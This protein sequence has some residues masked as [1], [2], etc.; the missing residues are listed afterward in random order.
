MSVGASRRDTGVPNRGASLLTDQDIA[1]LVRST[2]LAANAAREESELFDAVL[3]A[4]CSYLDWEAAAIWTS[5][6]HGGWYPGWVHVA[7]GTATHPLRTALTEASVPAGGDGSVLSAIVSSNATGSAWRLGDDP[8]WSV[9]A[10]ATRAGCRT[11]LCLGIEADGERSHLLQLLTSEARRPARPVVSGLETISTQLGHVVQRARARR[12]LELQEDELRAAIDRSVDAFLAS[13]TAGRIREWNRAAADLFGW[14][15]EEVLG[16]R[17]S[18]FLIPP[19]LRQAHE[20]D[21]RRYVDTGRSNLIDRATETPALHRDGHEI[22]VEL[23]LWATGRGPEGPMRLNAFVRDLT[24][25]YAA[26]AALR[27]REEQLATAQRQA[28]LGLFSWDLSAERAW[29]SPLALELL[30]FDPTGEPTAEDVVDRVHPDDRAHARAQL[31]DSIH[32]GNPLAFEHRVQRPD[33]TVRWV[34]VRA[35]AERGDDGRT[36]RL[37]GGMQDITEECELRAEL[38]RR[39]R[40]DVLTGLPNRVAFNEHLAQLGE[41][42]PSGG[43]IVALFD[44]DSLKPVNNRY[45]TQA[46]D[47]LLRQMAARLRSRLPVGAVPARL[48]G[49][50]F[51]VAATINDIDLTDLLD[52]IVDT[53]TQPFRLGTAK[54]RRTVSLGAAQADDSQEVE[55]LLRNADIA[56]YLAKNEGGGRARVFDPEMHQSMLRRMTLVADLE[57]AVEQGTIDVHYQPIVE[58]GGGRV[59]GF[60]ALA[61]WDRPRDGAVPPDVFIPLAEE[62]GL[63]RALGVHVLHRACRQLAAWDELHP[64]RRMTMAVNL[65]PRDLDSSAI[66]DEVTRCLDDHGLDP[67]RLV[68][69]ITEGDLPEDSPGALARLWDLRQLGVGLAIDDFGTGYSSLSRLREFSF[70]LLKVDRSFVRDIRDADEEPA[71]LQ[72]LVRM[73]RELGLRVLVEGIETPSQLDVV[74]RY[75]VDEVQGFLFS[76][77]LT[78][79]DATQMLRESSEVVVGDEQLPRRDPAADRTRPAA[80]VPL[81]SDTP[82]SDAGAER[83][84]ESIVERTGMTAAYLTRIEPDDGQQRVVR[85]H[86]ASGVLIPMGA[87]MPW[88]TSICHQLLLDDRVVVSDASATYPDTVATE[89]GI[90]THVGVP[91]PNATGGL[92]GTLAA[93]SAEVVDISDDDIELVRLLAQ[94][95]ADHL[96]TDQLG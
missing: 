79:M 68:L 90:R 63:I 94:L 7:G 85:V 4:L 86:D 76:R 49:G 71:L 45:G 29:W 33:G 41:D 5:D 80:A 26:E 42:L 62:R 59:V 44:I 43:V 89:L 93:S 2:A 6:A 51:A 24:P 27:Q 12:R 95:L 18:D 91:V 67:D 96:D 39:G 55:H 70:D 57:A 81:L 11:A 14:S 3:P 64:D 32:N 69:E 48:A 54:V 46:G 38:R 30:G 13:D 10:A 84:L 87:V 61:R 83:L 17:I 72:T 31:V 36:A 60:E 9:T 1:E 23:S 21:L 88:E 8:D 73:G 34:R 15:R 25:R 35:D 50:E 77:P 16:H 65:S 66:L 75:G 28:K 37:A 19:R 47:E 40:R 74:L 22:W 82:G 20:T 52:R 53:T 56:M 92:F 78:A 58:L